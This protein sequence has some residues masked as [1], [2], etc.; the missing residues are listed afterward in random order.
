MSINKFWE[1]V[2]SNLGFEKT[3]LAD[4]L[5]FRIPIYEAIYLSQVLGSTE[6]RTKSEG[7]AYIFLDNDQILMFPNPCPSIMIGSVTTEIKYQESIEHQLNP[8]LSPSLNFIREGHPQFFDKDFKYL[9]FSLGSGAVEDVAKEENLNTSDI[10]SL[11]LPKNKEDMNEPLMTYIVSSFLR[12]KGFI[13]DS[14]NEALGTGGF[15]D[16]FAFKLPQIQNKLAHLGIVEVGF[17]LNELELMSKRKNFTKIDEEKSIVIEIKRRGGFYNGKDQVMKY[18]R[19]GYYN[20]GYIGVPF[21]E[22]RIDS[23]AER[24]LL[25]VG[26]ITINEEG[27]ILMKGC[28]KDYGVNKNLLDVKKIV[29]QIIKLT[30][31]K[32]LSLRQVFDLF[33]TA[34]SFYD[35][36]FAVDKLEVGKI[37]SYVKQK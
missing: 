23:W 26:A 12:G 8:L 22:F 3:V 20:E 7:N 19:D 34:S 4:R 5:A 37:V 15:P 13:V 31:L 2:F 30:L 33:P 27:Q 25:D 18:L 9:M 24:D 28:P 16:L 10:V 21:E 11:L 6:W 17:Y 29:E 35:L 1:N 32:S 14:F 36:Y